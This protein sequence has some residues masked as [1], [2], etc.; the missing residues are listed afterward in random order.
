MIRLTEKWRRE[1]VVHSALEGDLRREDLGL[2]ARALEAYGKEGIEEVHLVV[3]GLLPSD[4]TVCKGL[5]RVEPEGMKL[6]LH[7]SRGFLRD[8]L[9][10]YGMEVSP[11][12]EKAGG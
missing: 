11:L 3:D 5:G 1:A 9:A 7:S 6:R 12:E 10:S 4:P 8:L 2:V